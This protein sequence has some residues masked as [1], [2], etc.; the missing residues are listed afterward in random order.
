MN[1]GQAMGNKVG[2]TTAVARL[3]EQGR[4]GEAALLVQDLL[5][6]WP[7][8]MD[9]LLLQAIMLIQQGQAE[10]A[11]ALLAELATA[12][13]D[14]ADVIGNLG[15]AHLMLDRQAEAL[16]CLERAVLLA[17]DDP[18]RRRDLAR[19]LLAQDPARAR[20]EIGRMQELARD[21]DD[22][23]LRAE[24]WSLAAVLL[25][26]E[27]RLAAAEEALRHALAFRPGHGDDLVLLAMILAQGGRVS[28]ALPVA[29]QA[30]LAA[31]ADHERVLMLAACLFELD[32]AD[33]AERLIRRVLAAAPLHRGALNA[34]AR[35]LIQRGD[36]AAG[37][38][39]FAPAVRRAGQD[40]AVLMDMARLLRL[41]GDLEKA[42][43]FV[44]EALRYAP[45][46]GEGRALRAH[47]LAALGRFDSLW[48]APAGAQVPSALVV[49][50]GLAAS[51]I[52]LLARFAARAAGEGARLAVHAEPALTPLLEGMSGIRCIAGPAPAEAVSLGQLPE[53][54][55][56]R[57]ADLAAAPYLAVEAAHFSRWEEMLSELPRPLI[58]LVWEKGAQGAT[59]ERLCR[60]LSGLGTPVSLA[61]DHDGK[62][63][64]AHPEVVDAGAHFGDARDL[65]AAIAH[66]DHVCGGDGLALHMAG[67]MARPATVVIP[68]ALPWAWAHR[69]GRSLWYPSVGVV[70]QAVAGDWDRPLAAME[71]AVRAALGSVGAEHAQQAEKEMAQ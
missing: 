45:D 57:P 44:G 16:V 14:R 66:M 54:M 37:L 4:T 61:F 71:Q 5:A 52:V 56:V 40:A 27:G 25:L 6:D 46:H 28:E 47:L 8:D 51:D 35:L 58:G 48:P 67:A 2:R 53:I 62:A 63:L 3:L 20:A 34:L 68:P 11:F 69:E 59:L 60:A 33:E 30:Y 39:A 29:E 21:L 22:A 13:P 32:K 43:T 18:R 55:G 65:A 42:L 36:A 9:A 64:S 15:I 49:P 41:S 26:Q 19:L 10:Q 17:P 38:A 12:V 7:Q 50:E 31:P 23:G 70:R 24:G 1:T